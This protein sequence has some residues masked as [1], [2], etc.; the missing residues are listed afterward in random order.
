MTATPVARPAPTPK[1]VPAWVETRRGF[2]ADA[3]AAELRRAGYDVPRAARAS[4]AERAAIFA[5]AGLTPGSG[6]S[7]RMA[8]E[9]LAGSVRARNLCTGCLAGDPAGVP[10]PPKPYGH[11]PPCTR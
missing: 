8:V 6:A 10:G 11:A 1:G 9:R 3:I 7:Y 5:A 4:V 2:R